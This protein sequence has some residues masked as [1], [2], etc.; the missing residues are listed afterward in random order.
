MTRDTYLG[1]YIDPLSLN[2]YTYAHNN[3]IRYCDPSGYAVTQADIDRAYANNSPSEAKK[4]IEGIAAATNAWNNATTQAQKDAAHAEADRLRGITTNSNGSTSGASGGN[5][6][7]YLNTSDAQNLGKALTSAKEGM[8]TSKSNSGSSINVTAD[9]SLS[10]QVE[11]NIQSAYNAWQGGYIPF[12]QYIDNVLLNLGIIQKSTS[13]VM[14]SSIMR[15]SMSK[16]SNS[17]DLDGDE[18]YKKDNP[19]V[20][21][22]LVDLA[23][24]YRNVVELEQ[25]LGIELSYMK[26][27]IKELQNKMRDIGNNKTVSINNIVDVVMLTQ[28]CATEHVLY[29][30]S[31]VKGAA[32]ASASVLAQLEYNLGD[33]DGTIKNARLHALWNAYSIMM[34][35]GDSEY[36]KSFTDAHEYGK[37]ANFTDITAGVGGTAYQYVQMDLFNNAIG[38]AVGEKLFGWWSA[39]SPAGTLLSARYVIGNMPSDAF[40]VVIK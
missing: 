12:E 35:L 39:L 2:R 26:K 33:Y 29:A 28:L 30:S 19:I 31:P 27:D 1:N 11:S 23:N 18:K 15:L 22:A 6:Y 25:K 17:Y 16:I 24:S 5:T 9:L 14:G 13:Q 10:P 4:I 3:P 34:T 8:S 32:I 38:R 40:M 7:V 37:P 20:Y 36:V 21:Q